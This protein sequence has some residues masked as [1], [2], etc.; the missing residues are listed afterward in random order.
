MTFTPLFMPWSF[1]LI[2]AGLFTLVVIGMATATVQ[3]RRR[4]WWRAAGVACLCAAIARPGIGTQAASIPA[5]NTDVVFLVDVSPSM[6]AEDWHGEGERLEGVREDIMALAQAHAGARFAVIT[7]N[8]DAIQVQPF[9]RDVSALQATTENLLPED[10]FA[11]A[12]SSIFAG[13][14]ALDELLE[15]TR[16]DYPDHARL[17]YYF[18]DG[19]ATADDAIGSFNG[20]ADE[21]QGGA[22]FGYGTE[23]GARIPEYD[24]GTRTGDY[25]RDRMG[26]PGISQLDSDALADI[27]AQLD[28]PME[29]RDA[30]TEIVAA[31]VHSERVTPEMTGD[32][33]RVTTPVY[34]VFAL[35]VCAWLL[36]EIW[37]AVRGMRLLRDELNAAA[38]TLPADTMLP[39]NERHRDGGQHG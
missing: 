18:G 3:T 8:S 34:W 15:R 26:E 28:V 36:A 24:S 16:S 12:G 7:F 39:A 5:E 19:E 23:R 31:E 27:A 11:S 20:V 22:V 35:G 32:T 21:I 13:S 17:V 30:G 37:F 9:M 4:W 1:W 38:T 33:I 25:I 6:A 29:I 14:T 2:C 10:A